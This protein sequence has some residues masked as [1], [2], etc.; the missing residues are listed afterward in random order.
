MSLCCVENIELF[1]LVKGY[2]GK[3]L[4]IK[5]KNML[6]ATHTR[7]MFVIWIL[8]MCKGIGIVC[9]KMLKQ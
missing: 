8:A 6:G 1:S 7:E 2:A 3:S 4:K 5:I 9:P